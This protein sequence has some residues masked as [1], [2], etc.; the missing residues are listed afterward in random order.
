MHRFLRFQNCH[1][2]PT[3]I[4]QLQTHCFLLFHSSFVYS[5]HGKKLLTFHRTPSHV[6]VSREMKRWAK[7]LT[8]LSLSR[9][10]VSNTSCHWFFS[11][12][13]YGE[14]ILTHLC[15]GHTNQTQL[16]YV[17][18]Q[19][20]PPSLSVLQF[21]SSVHSSTPC[22]LWCTVCCIKHIFPRLHDIKFYDRLAYISDCS[23]FQNDVIF[24]FLRKLTFLF[25]IQ[26]ISVAGLILFWQSVGPG[27][28]FPTQ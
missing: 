9:Q 8:T 13:L 7:Q 15:F 20:L 6:C 2:F 18:R 1:I 25:K 10:P 26:N 12:C 19:P 16:Y 24:V 27:I 4:I 28:G 23:Y 5:I 3:E 22:L 11:S 21:I 14:V 17:K